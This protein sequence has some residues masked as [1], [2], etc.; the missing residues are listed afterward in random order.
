MSTAT[1]RGTMAPNI[2]DLVLAEEEFDATANEYAPPKPVTPAFYNV[3]LSFR[4][5]DPDRRFRT[6]A[7]SA[8]YPTKE[9]KGYK[10]TELL[11]TIVDEG[12]EFQG[13]RLVDDFMSTGIFNR[14]TSSMASLILTLGGE[15]IGNEGHEELCTVL[16]GLM[17]ADPIV[18]VKSN[19]AW[20]GSKEGGYVKI[21]GQK[22]FPKDEDGNPTHIIEDEATGDKIAGY[23]T[24]ERYVAG[25]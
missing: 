2:N 10:V 13:R 18:R 19:W 20:R 22:N 1:Q 17:A 16:E 11:G 12:S 6:I 23:G 14:S 21:R 15:L 9:G 8:K 5:E 4:E 7:Y 3:R 25:N 24:I